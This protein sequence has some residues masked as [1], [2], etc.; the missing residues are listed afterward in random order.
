MYKIPTLNACIWLVESSNKAANNLSTPRMLCIH[1]L[2]CVCVTVCYSVCD[3]SMAWRSVT[4]QWH[5]ICCSSVG[6]VTDRKSHRWTMLV[7]RLQF[8]E[9]PAVGR[10]Q[11]ESCRLCCHAAER[12]LCQWR[13][14]KFEWKCDL[15]MMSL[16][17]MVASPWQLP[18]WLM[19]TV[20]FSIFKAKIIM[21]YHLWGENKTSA[22]TP[23]LN[24][25]DKLTW[26]QFVISSLQQHD[27]KHTQ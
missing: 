9:S 10:N 18:S 17:W 22:V 14:D 7:V 2:Q 24:I 8:P 20:V 16:L 1:V 27:Q 25:C 26:E 11:S 15:I 3:W 19:A 23:V 5:W 6:G 13:T 4:S 21:T 12:E